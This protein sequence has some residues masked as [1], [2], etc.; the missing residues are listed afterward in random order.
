MR[1]TRPG[2][3]ALP[4]V[5]VA[6]FDPVT[7]RYI[8]RVT[9]S[10]AIRVVDVP[11]FDPST[12]DYVQPPVRDGRRPGLASGGQMAA[13]LALGIVATILATLAA[14]TVRKRWRIDPGSW[15][16]RRARG[17][18]PRG[19]TEAVAREIVEI[20]AEYLERRIGRPL[21]VLTPEEAHSAIAKATKDAELGARCAQLVTDCDRA[22][23]S[24]SATGMGNGE[25]VDEARRLF[26][27]IGRKSTV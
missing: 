24:L 13:G 25:L 14:W 5:A 1:P 11:R 27:E 8:T 21:G 7:A 18:D 20:L 26:K 4:P 15:I 22:S 2:A 19:G 16:I 3:A 9:A 10:V 17:L 6:A 23:Y 12:L